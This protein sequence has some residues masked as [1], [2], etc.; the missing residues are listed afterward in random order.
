MTHRH[1]RLV[2]HQASYELRIFIRNPQARVL[3]IGLPPLF[4]FLFVSMLGNQ[5]THADGH[6]MRQSVYYVPAVTVF[7]IVDSAFMAVLAWLV[8]SR[9]L[10]IFKRR[11][12]TPVPVWVIVAGRVVSTAVGTVAMVSILLIL[13]AAAYG[14][15][16]PARTAVALIVYSALGTVV[17]C[18]LAF[19]LSSL[20]RN[21]DAAVPMAM[22]FALPLLF[23][24]GVYIPWAAVPS[25]LRI[26]A[27]IFPVRALADGMV[28]VYDPATKGT[29]L[30][31]RDVAVLIAWGVAGLLAAWGRFQWEPFADRPVRR[32]LRPIPRRKAAVTVVDP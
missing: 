17:L 6:A 25:F 13:G 24:S 15:H 12:A 20:I 5:L 18:V 29:A 8:V 22:A 1:L 21:G 2:V 14:V 3:T 26:V 19:A 11:R 28:R 27:D 31:G 32:H 10:G 9:E 4:L 23:I 16:P 30:V 7:G